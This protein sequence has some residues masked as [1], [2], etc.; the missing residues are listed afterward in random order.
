MLLCKLE[1]SM[2]RQG[3]H[4]ALAQ[5]VCLSGYVWLDVRTQLAVGIDWRRL[6]GMAYYVH[7]QLHHVR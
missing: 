6:F 1:D 2:G 5:A 4:C 3:E 7:L